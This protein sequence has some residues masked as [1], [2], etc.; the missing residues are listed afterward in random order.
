MNVN[1]PDLR[2]C[3]VE[4]IVKNQAD[5]YRLAF[6]YVK[7]QEAALDV[8]Q[9]AVVKALSGVDSLRDPD[10]VRTW[11]CRILVNECMNYF[12][13]SRNLVPYD[14]ALDLCAAGGPDPVERMDLYAAIDRLSLQEQGV[15]RLRFFHDMKL[16]EIAQSTGT[17]L[18]TVKSRLYKALKKLRELTREEIDDAS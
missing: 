15:I 9:E 16:E 5:F 6:S 18:N 11:F 4:H 2:Q 12:R 14:G 7:N 10:R 17:N 8:V 1:A 3:L 13:R